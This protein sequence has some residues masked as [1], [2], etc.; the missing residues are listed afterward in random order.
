MTAANKWTNDD[1]IL[2][3]HY[4]RDELLSCWRVKPIPD[5]WKVIFKTVGCNTPEQV[6]KMMEYYQERAAS[7]DSEKKSELYAKII[8]TT[9]MHYRR[10]F[11]DELENNPLIFQEKAF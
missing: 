9:T 4:E 8:A 11:L 1:N 2:F 10:V 6:A 3:P 7:D 5:D